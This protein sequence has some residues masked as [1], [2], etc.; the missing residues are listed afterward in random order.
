MR[1]RRPSCISG[2]EVVQ[3]DTMRAIMKNDVCGEEERRR[4]LS[5]DARTSSRSF[6]VCFPSSRRTTELAGLEPLHL[7]EHPGVR[8]G[9]RAF[10]YP[11]LVAVCVIAVVMRIKSETG[12]ASS[13][14]FTE[15]FACSRAPDGKFASMTSTKS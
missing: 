9:G 5:F 4:L 2:T 12:L 3:L 8:D 14:G 11:H 13:W 6:A 10:V 7:I 1:S 15:I